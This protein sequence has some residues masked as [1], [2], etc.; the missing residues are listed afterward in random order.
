[1]KNGDLDVFMGYWDPA[2]Q[3]YFAPYRKS[4]AVETIH[5]NL[6]GAKFTWVVPSYVYDAGM[7]SFA[8][9]AAHAD[10]FGKKIYGIEPGSNEIMLGIV[11]KG[12]FGLGDWKVVE[13]SEQGML[14]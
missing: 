6:E 4:G 12:D 9:L 1:M 14:S 13:S 3:S 11:K 10:K 5:T 8:D 7:H 2:M